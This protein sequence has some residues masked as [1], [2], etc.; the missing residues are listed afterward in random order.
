MNTVN[1]IING[2][3][4]SNGRVDIFTPKT[5]D[6]FQM[7]DKIPVNQC[8]TLRNPTEGLWDNTQLSN[9]FFS[10]E[11]IEIIQNGIRAG[12]YN[13]SNGKYV[14]ANQECETL[15]IIMRSI[16]LQYA[17]NQPTNIKGQV[18]QLNKMV[19]DYCIPQV[20]GE[21]QGYY[22]Y[23]VDASTMYTPMAPPIMSSNN[24]KQLILK[25]WF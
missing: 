3:K 5:T 13:H 25:P 18:E 24:D 10:K 1:N 16:F 22:K 4:V 7:Y 20:Y 17:A 12:V 15:K 23:I 14:I 9:T 21:A 6:L 2:K 11:N 8:A 19:L